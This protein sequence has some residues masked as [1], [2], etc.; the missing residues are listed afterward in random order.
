MQPLAVG[1]SLKTRISLYVPFEVGHSYHVGF[2]QKV[3]LTVFYKIG[4]KAPVIRG[5]YYMAPGAQVAG[6][7]DVGEGVSFWFNAVVRADDDWVY[8][9]D[10]SNIQENAVVHVDPGSPVR[11]GKGVIVGHKAML[12]SCIIEDECLIGMNAVILNNARIGKNSLIGANTLI[13]ENM[14]VPE[15]SLVVGSPGKVVRKLKDNE[16]AMMAGGGKYYWEKALKLREGLEPF[17]P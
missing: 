15:G 14:E 12:H 11:I 9:G 7:V 16:L 13:P 10:Y 5:D 17:T 1:L 3:N 8:I 2:S 6:A 4:D